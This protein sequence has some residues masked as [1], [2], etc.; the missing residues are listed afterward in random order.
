VL[1]FAGYQK[2]KT[3]KEIDCECVTD[4]KPKFLQTKMFL[5]LLTVFAIVMMAFPY[6]S[7]I[8]SSH[9]VQQ[10]ILVDKSDIETTEFNIR[11]RTCASGEAQVNHELDKF[12]GMVNSKASYKN[13]N[14]IIEFDRTQ[15]LRLKRV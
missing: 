14:A 6:Y 9:T 1:G 4:E 13:G 11:G 5:G 15:T 7:G 2:L 3:K 12:K 10:I 8:F